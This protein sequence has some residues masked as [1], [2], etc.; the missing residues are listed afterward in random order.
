LGLPAVAT[1]FNLD[2]IS[3]A[4]VRCDLVIPKDLLNHTGV[5]MALDTLQMKAFRKDLNDLPGY[6][7]AC[8][9]KIMARF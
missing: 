4:Q 3:F 5:R 1:A 2:F 9:G 8:S 6:D 7:T